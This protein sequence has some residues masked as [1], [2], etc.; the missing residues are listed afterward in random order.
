M[1]VQLKRLRNNNHWYSNSKNCLFK[2]SSHN[3]IFY[4]LDEKPIRFLRKKDCEIIKNKL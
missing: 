4:I 1:I 2:V 3:S